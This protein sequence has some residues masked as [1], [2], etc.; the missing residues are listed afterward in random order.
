MNT[1]L[2]AFIEPCAGGLTAARGFFAGGAKAGIKK[3]GD[4][5]LGVVHSQAPCSAA[6]AFT[7]NSVRAACIEWN[8]RYLPGDSL[9][10]I[11]CN[12]G[13]ANACTGARGVRN[14]RETADK[15]AELLGTPVESI[16]IASTGVIGEYLPMESINA[17]LPELTASLSPDGGEAFARSIMTTDTV[18]KEYAVSVELS[19]GT[20]IIGGC[21]KGSGMIC[22]NMAT[23]LAFITTDFAINAD[24]LN[25]IVKTNV[26]KTFNNLTID[27]DTSTNDMV[28]A[29]ANGMSAASVQ[30]AE[31]KER[32]NE[33]FHRVCNALCEKIAEDGEGATK[34]VEVIVT[35][36]KTNADCRLAAKAIAN[37]SLVKTA[38]FGNDPNWGRI[39]CAIGYS[40]ARFSTAKVSVS[41]CGTPVCA[42]LKPLKFDAVALREAMK[43][44]IITIEADLGMSGKTAAV[45]HTCDLTYEYIKINAEYHT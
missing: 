44:S 33:A 36:G 14:V 40:G 2:S 1:A 6:G 11:C 7:L 38:M 15:V 20:G 16:M 18:Q 4:L 19:S 22:P 45:A 39:L 8:Q 12:S 30:T 9:F 34:R 27:G 17:A 5:D 10:A 28:L 37:S 31:D 32:F 35:G 21:A 29:L 25:K 3:S 42:Q 26:D 23:M 13:N 43:E 24:T 41:L